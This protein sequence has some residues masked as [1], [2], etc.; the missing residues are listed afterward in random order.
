[1]DDII[2][3]EHEN[4]IY[5]LCLSYLNKDDLNYISNINIMQ[6]IDDQINKG[7][8]KFKDINNKILD[9][10]DWRKQNNYNNI[11]KQKINSIYPNWN[12]YIYGVDNTGH[13]LCV[14][15][16]D[17]INM[18][19]INDINI[20]DMNIFY[21]QKHKIYDEIN[22]KHSLE[23]KY[24]ICKHSIIVDVENIGMNLVSANSRNVIKH[25][26]E[27]NDYYFPESI[28]NVFIINSP[29]V[30]KMVYSIV[31]HW[32]SESTKK[33]II[34]VDNDKIIDTLLSYGFDYNNIPE[35]L[36]GNHK[37]ISIIKKIIS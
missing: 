17:K 3:S 21:A 4:K 33:K 15:K 24:I 9:V 6:I 19:K 35:Y 36:G 16:V 20:N 14:M 25:L 34:F 1:M 8:E 32:I 27:F 2:L 28:K 10:L 22:R 13:T 11:L 26:F 31:K 30:F 37:G 29:F 5:Q 23:K 12:E 7:N 18:E